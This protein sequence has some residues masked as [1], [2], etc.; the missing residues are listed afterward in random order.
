MA[1]TQAGGPDV[2]TLTEGQ[3]TRSHLLV[4]HPRRLPAAR[5]LAHGRAARTSLFVVPRSAPCPGSSSVLSADTRPRGGVASIGAPLQGGAG[6]SGERSKMFIQ[7]IQGQCKDADRVHQLMVGLRRLRT[8]LRE[9][10][11]FSTSR[12]L[13]SWEAPLARTFRLLGEVRDTET[14]VAAMAPR[15]A[16]NGVTEVPW[17]RPDADHDLALFVKSKDFQLALASALIYAVTD[18]DVHESN[19]HGPRHHVK[20]RL[21]A[22]HG[23]LIKDG[24]RFRKLPIEA[25]HGVRKRLKRMRYLAEFVQPLFET[26]KVDGYLAVMRPAQ[27]ELGLHNDY[28]VALSLLDPAAISN[29]GNQA[30]MAIE[31]LGRKLKKSDRKSEKALQ[32]LEAAPRFWKTS[33]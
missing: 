7:V 21:K 18:D 12:D 2:L 10:Q 17:R 22:L 32:K 25:Q 15:L 8:A 30:S 27:E 31:W 11:R 33:T 1:M 6:V 29:V 28:A 9:L 5:N 14:V 13:K 24:R 19:S 20:K 3:G 4:D 23:R 26:G 16:K